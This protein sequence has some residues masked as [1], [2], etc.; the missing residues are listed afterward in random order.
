MTVTI[1]LTLAKQVEFF[2]EY[3]RNKIYREIL[4]AANIIDKTNG[5][6]LKIV[7]GEFNIDLDMESK[8]NLLPGGRHTL[9]LLNFPVSDLTSFLIKP[10]NLRLRDVTCHYASIDEVNSVYRNLEI[11]FEQKQMKIKVSD[12]FALGTFTLGQTEIPF[13]IQRYCQGIKLTD[14]VKEEHSLV[15]SFL[16]MIFKH[17]AK[18]GFVI[19]PYPQN[20]YVHG[21]SLD[22][23]SFEYET[24]EYIDLAYFHS[25]QTNVEIK[26]LLKSLKPI[27]L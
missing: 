9:F 18:E 14:L 8:N 1:S 7:N 2:N 5:K 17:L 25:L 13:I 19:D 16:P 15:H 23:R 20:W 6:K 4:T 26:R 24:L 21:S 10:Y 22:M 11:P 12:V 3:V 27:N